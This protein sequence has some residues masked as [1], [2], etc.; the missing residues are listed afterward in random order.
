[1]NRCDASGMHIA[2]YNN[3]YMT[4]RYQHVK[5][6]KNVETENCGK[7]DT[8]QRYWTTYGQKNKYGNQTGRGG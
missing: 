8:M 6:K 3:D 2:N 5:R 7:R 4:I 1:M